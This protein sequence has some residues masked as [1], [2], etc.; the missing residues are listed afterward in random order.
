LE[1]TPVVAARTVLRRVAD[2]RRYFETVFG[3]TDADFN[4]V[5]TGV[6]G[7]DSAETLNK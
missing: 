6:E 2:P 5:T 1:K 3:R 4:N 7:R